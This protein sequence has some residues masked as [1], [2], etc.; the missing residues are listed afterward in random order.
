MTFQA[1]SAAIL[2]HVSI[3]QDLDKLK[4][5]MTGLHCIFYIDIFDG[6][7]GASIAIAQF[8]LFL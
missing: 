8:V 2:F 3:V 5:F 6:C 7:F 4:M 1:V